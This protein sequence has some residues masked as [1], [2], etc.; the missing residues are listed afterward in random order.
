MEL[1]DMNNS[2]YPKELYESYKKTITD[3]NMYFPFLTLIGIM[4]W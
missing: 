2:K 1:A 4:R 3:Y